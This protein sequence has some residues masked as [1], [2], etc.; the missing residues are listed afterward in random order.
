MPVTWL[1]SKQTPV[2]LFHIGLGIPAATTLQ[3]VMCGIY[4]S[5][6]RK[7]EKEGKNC[8]NCGSVENCIERVEK[9]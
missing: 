7:Q 8:E 1:M 3:I 4:F 5:R 2:S 9:K 6:M